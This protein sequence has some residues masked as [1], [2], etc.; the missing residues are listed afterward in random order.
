MKRLTPHKSKPTRG[1][2]GLS[3][4]SPNAGIDNRLTHASM[5]LGYMFKY[6]IDFRRR[7]IN[8]TGE[9]DDDMFELVDQALTE[10]EA[11]SRKFITIKINSPGGYCYQA[12]AIVGR[13]RESKCKIV[14]KGYGEIMSAATL[15]LASGDVR[16]VSKHAVFMYHEPS[17]G[18]YDR[19][20]MNRDLI[21]Q[22]ELE[23]KQWASAME[24]FTAV[25]QSFWLEAGERKDAYFTAQQ[26]LDM[27]VV[28]EIF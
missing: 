22:S 15:I 13:I 6:G 10:M 26:L 28:H 7:I 11:E 17:Y 23:N 21:V 14:V 20:T 12:L 9:V 1:A 8:L 16:K 27:G 19:H 24:E 18:F 25:P 5:L 4:I 2:T 3:K